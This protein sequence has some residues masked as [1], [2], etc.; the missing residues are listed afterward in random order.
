MAF[1]GP[2]VDGDTI[3]SKAFDVEGCLEYIRVVGSTAVA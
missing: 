1:V 3:G 2:G